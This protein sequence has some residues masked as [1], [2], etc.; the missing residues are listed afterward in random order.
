MDSVAMDTEDGSMSEDD[1]PIFK[2]DEILGTK[3]RKV[4]M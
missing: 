2:I 1:G 3:I 4:S